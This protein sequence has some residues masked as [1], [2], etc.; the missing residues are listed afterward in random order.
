MEYKKDNVAHCMAYTYVA[1]AHLT[2]GAVDEAEWKNIG[3]KCWAWIQHFDMDIDGDGELNGDDIVSLIFDCV[4]PFYDSMTTE[5]KIEE[6]VRIQV[7]LKAQDWWT[8]DTS[9][10][11]LKDMK[12][13]AMADGVF[14]EGEEK[15]LEIMAKGFGVAV[16]A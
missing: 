12:N 1:F 13:L 10:A 14:A 8:D 11:Y 7:V 16:P 4:V 15:F 5:E 9:A 6:F 3:G 2:D